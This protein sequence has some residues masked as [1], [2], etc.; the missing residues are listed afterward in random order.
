MLRGYAWPGNVRELRNLMKRLAVLASDAVVPEAFCRA[1][2]QLAPDATEASPDAAA[3]LSSADAD[4]PLTDA[5]D[6]YERRLLL[7]RLARTD[8]TKAEAARRLG[9]SERTLW[10]KLKKHGLRPIPSA[11][12]SRTRRCPAIHAAHRPRSRGPRG[13]MAARRAAR[14]AGRGAAQ[15]SAPPRRR[16]GVAMRP[17]GPPL[18]RTRNAGEGVGAPLSRMSCA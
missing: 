14:G 17:N 6:R 5:V 11:S 8:D 13:R 7:H 9:I 4:Q 12:L 10:Y 1:M 3:D 2:L 15:P 16:R 18:H